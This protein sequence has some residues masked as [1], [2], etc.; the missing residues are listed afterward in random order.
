MKLNSN[1][2]VLSGMNF[3]RAFTLIELLVVIA[4]IA[5]LAALLLPVLSQ[6][7]EK[8]RSIQCLNNMK[9]LAL[10]W[11]MYAGD[12]DDR[13]PLNWADLQS[14][15]T[16]GSWVTG[17]VTLSN[18]T[19][20]ITS[21]TLFPYHKSLAVYRC[22]DLGQQN[23][24]WLTRSVSMM[25]RMGGTDA[26]EAARYNLYDSSSNL[27][28]SVFKR[29]TQINNPGP[30]SAIVFVDES[31]NSVDDGIFVLTQTQ[32]ENTPTIRHN[33]GSAFS[34]ADGHVER[35]RWQGLNQELG[36]LVTPSGTAQIS[37]FQRLLAA[38][39]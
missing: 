7:K 17:N 22:P 1:K 2:G 20:D 34:F 11:I 23:G 26:A 25:E 27:G 31:Q 12:N 19:N 30:S 29:T 6:A 16:A 35:W 3:R 24:R 18:T 10:S 4:I 33:R 37:D 8:A 32:W 21:G 15:S 5:I 39:L 13:V 14:I 9:Q 36:V 38:E 28:V